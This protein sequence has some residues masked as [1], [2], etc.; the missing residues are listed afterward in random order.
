MKK[1]VKEL[2]H[3]LEK[4]TQTGNK[5]TIV[6]KDISRTVYNALEHKDI[7]KLSDNAKTLFHFI[8][9]FGKLHSVRGDVE[10]NLFE[11]PM[12]N[13]ES[14][15]CGIFQLYFYK[16]LFGLRENSKIIAHKNLI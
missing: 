5:I 14:K 15:Y 16:N 9:A 13:I 1:I 3:R 2:F 6:R 8:N 12:Q 4:M 10:V 7:L 11:N